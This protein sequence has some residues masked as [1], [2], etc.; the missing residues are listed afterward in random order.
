MHFAEPSS[1]L[2][3][4]F[5]GDDAVGRVKSRGEPRIEAVP[6]TLPGGGRQPERRPQAP[7][8]TLV[9]RRAA[10]QVAVAAA[11]I[12]G[13]R[14]AFAAEKL[15]PAPARTKDRW[16]KVKV[17][18]DIQGE[19][20][21][22]GEGS[23]TTRSALEVS[24]QQAYLERLAAAGSRLEPLASVRHYDQAKAD[25]RVGA[26]KHQSFLDPARQLVAMQVVDGQPTLF[27]PVAPLTR[28]ELDLLE[29][30]CNTA[31]LAQL[32]PTKAVAVGETWKASD[33]AWAQIL[34]LETLQQND[35]Q[36][37]LDRWE[38]PAAMLQAEG[39]LQ[40]SVGGVST[41]IEVKAKIQYDRSAD[42]ITWIALG[43]VEDRAIGHAEPGFKANIRVRVALEP[44]AEDRVLADRALAELPLDAAQAGTLVAFSAERSGLRLLLDRRWRIMTNRPNNVVLRYVDQ[45]DLLGQCNLS[46][47]PRLDDGKTL[48]LEELQEDI[49]LSLGKSFQQFTAAN[50]FE[51]EGKRILRVVAVGVASELPIQWVYHH[52]TDD[53]GRRFVAVFTVEADLVER[54][55][56][57]DRTLV[58]AIEVV[59]DDDGTTPDKAE[60]NESA[61][62]TDPAAAP[63]RLK[64]ALKTS[65]RPK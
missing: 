55:A 25:F 53:Q 32:L 41:D 65:A 22:R 64:S 16:Q 63:A 10:L 50:Q 3:S 51:E 40:G 21:L 43:L 9:S 20:K 47:L 46:R 24:S 56:E 11:W 2:P 60:K 37:K 28:S 6:S 14:P 27:S 5:S 29:T 34:G 31:L 38:G 62:K 57:A 48:P 26:A 49:R 45:G 13:V 39:T 44:A 30:P 61:E 58:S 17:A 8:H 33:L 52:V 42:Q 23:K 35:V 4:S 15:V 54:F 7:G 36:L 19:L 1:F 59:A 18:V 12:G